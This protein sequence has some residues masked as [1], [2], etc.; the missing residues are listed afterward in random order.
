[1]IC[2]FEFL[3][4]AVDLDV[5]DW[6]NYKIIY[7]T[8]PEKSIT[9]PLKVSDIPRGRGVL[10]PKILEEKYDAK[11]E[12]PGG[13]GGAKQ[14]PSVGGVWLFSGNAHSIVMKEYW[15]FYSDLLDLIFS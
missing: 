8:V 14:K 3:L 5:Y 12:F 15:N 1:M 7:C 13:G 4:D 9:T 10:S 6:S 11:V 2:W